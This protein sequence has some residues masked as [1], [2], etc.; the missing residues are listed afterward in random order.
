M[1]DHEGEAETAAGGVAVAGSAWLHTS[2]I[3]VSAVGDNI[4]AADASD[5]R[6][7]VHALT[8]VATGGTNSV[9]LLSGPGGD[10]LTGPMD[11]ASDGQL[12][13]GWNPAGWFQTAAGA[14]LSLELSDANL[15]SGLLTVSYPT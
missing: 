7:R 6:I 4:I 2:A 9:R 15:V 3:S 13:L 14:A 8:L 10:A 11:L 1:A 12:R 5:R